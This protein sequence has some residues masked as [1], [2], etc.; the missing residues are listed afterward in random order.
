[1]VLHPFDVIFPNEG[2]TYKMDRFLLLVLLLLLLLLRTIPRER[3]IHE[4]L[5]TNIARIH[6]SFLKAST[7]S[8]TLCWPMQLD[9]MEVS[10]IHSNEFYKYL[11]E[12]Q[13]G[14]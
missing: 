10:K 6:S 9:L 13:K 1:M 11:S 14:K 7:V 8:S 4:L 3:L 5:E 2:H 12:E